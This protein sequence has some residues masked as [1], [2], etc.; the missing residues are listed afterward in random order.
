MRSPL[1]IW[2]TNKRHHIA[3]IGGLARLERLPEK[4][5]EELIVALAGPLVNV[6]LA[7]ITGFITFQKMQR[8]WRRNYQAV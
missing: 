3:S 1:K 6:L 7:I 2:N 4:P 5:A 8:C